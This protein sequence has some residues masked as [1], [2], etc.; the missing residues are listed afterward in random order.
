ME[1]D[2]ACEGQITT[3]K[4]KLDARKSL[5]KGGSI[6]LASDALDRGKKIRWY[7]VDE[8]L[9]K[10][11]KAITTEENKA[12]RK[13]HEEGVQSR[14][15]EKARRLFIQQAQN[16]GTFIPLSMWDL[17][18]DPEKI[19]TDAETAALRA[20]QSLH[21]AA[22]PAEDEWE[23]VRYENLAVFTSIPIDPVIIAK[24]REFQLR[25]RPLFQVPVDIDL[26]E[27]KWEGRET[28]DNMLTV[29]PVRSVVSVDSIIV[30]ADFI[31][32]E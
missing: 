25:Q 24:E 1:I 20:S 14:K 10:A 28:G 18:R 31:D 3:Y 26:E 6:I 11:R 2:L 13:L 5:Q 22:R 27:E 29:S 7:E 30:G 4:R 15:D 16:S 19:P 23:R 9:R 21:D 12:K 8:K 32:L 17:I